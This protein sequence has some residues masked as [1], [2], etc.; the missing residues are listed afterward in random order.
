MNIRYIKFIGLFKIFGTHQYWYVKFTNKLK[1]KT[2]CIFFLNISK[3]LG[4]P[5]TQHTVSDEVNLRWVLLFSYKALLYLVFLC[6]KRKYFYFFYLQICYWWRLF[7][8]LCLYGFVFHRWVTPNSKARM[9][10]NTENFD[11]VLWKYSIM[12]NYQ[13]K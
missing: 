7:R 10:Y 11:S 5:C 1:K 8:F 12:I 3:L 2:V 9:S 4:C 6:L 13:Q